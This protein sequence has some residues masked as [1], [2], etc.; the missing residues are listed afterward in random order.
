MWKTSPG[1]TTASSGR[2]S[3]H[4]GRAA[5]QPLQPHP[6]A[7]LR[8]RC[9]RV[10]ESYFFFAYPFLVSVP[11]YN[12]RAVGLPDAERDRN[13][14]ML[15]FIGEQ[16]AA[17]GMEF[18][19][20]LWTHAYEWPNSPRPNY[21]TEGL[22][23]A[24]HAPY[25]RDALAAMLQ[26][27]PAIGGL[28][29]RIHGE[30]G[31][32][33]G[34]Y[35]FWKTVF[36][37]VVRGGRRVEIDL[38]PKGIDQTTIDTGAGHRHAR[39][40]L[41]QVLGRAPRH[42]VP[43]GR[44]PRAGDARARAAPGSGLLRSATATRS[45]LRYGYGDMLREDRRYG[46]IHRVWPG[47]SGCCYGAIRVTAAA[48]ARAFSFCGSNGAEIMEPLTFKGRKGSGIAGR[49][50]APMPTPLSRPR[51]D[52]EK[53]EYTYRVMGPPALQSRFRPRRLA[54]LFARALSGS[55]GG[56]RRRAG[57]RRPH[58]AH[59]HHRASALGGQ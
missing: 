35:D 17:R 52:W 58:P 44:H 46:V 25:C 57:Q 48:Y 27:C 12:V 38:H 5:V 15:R 36:D 56:H 16:T 31:V 8:R 30:S 29:F 23:S 54:P 19:L 53:Y 55:R 13:L 2:L 24:N 34:S 42:A 20:G 43:P 1:S 4:A 40:A 47:R 41:T 45:F 22:N 51:W 37:G 33:E 28:T 14:E 18:Q 9:S 59:R 11:G 7:G 3:H 49:P 32:A 10:T 21:P 39:E 6:G 50:H 26:A